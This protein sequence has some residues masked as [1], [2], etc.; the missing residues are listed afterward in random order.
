MIELIRA[1]KRYRGREISCFVDHLVLERGE[2]V[3][4]LGDNGSGKTS[5]LKM[6]MGLGRLSNGTVRVDGKPPAEQYDRMAYVTEEGSWLPGM[7]PRDFGEFLSEFFPRFDPARYRRLLGSF[8][9][10]ETKPIRSMSKGQRAKV[11]LA[12]GFAK[13]ADYLLLDEPFLGVDGTTRRRFLGELAA[14]LTGEELVL[15]ATHFVEDFA[16]LFDRA[17]LFHGGRIRENVRIDDLREQGVSL[18]D[19]MTEVSLGK[20]DR[21][22][23]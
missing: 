21:T 14:E 17:L 8:E 3:G 10:E 2:I 20:R 13:R 7:S 1:Q 6:I 15:V 23:L 9:L 22:Y 18:A 5:F 4:V 16:N 11:E 19:R 12:A